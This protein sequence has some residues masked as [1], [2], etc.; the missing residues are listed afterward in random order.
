[1]F[2]P[3]ASGTVALAS[4]GMAVPASASPPKVGA[5]LKIASVEELV[6]SIRSGDPR[7]S[8]T[9]VRLWNARGP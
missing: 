6:G 8:L 4:G 3:S 2:S 9:Q 5:K 1:M 7:H